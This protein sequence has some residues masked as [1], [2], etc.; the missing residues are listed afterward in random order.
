MKLNDRFNMI[1]RKKQII[2][3]S[4][5]LILFVF[6][7]LGGLTHSYASPEAVM[8]ACEKGLHYG[9]SEK[10]LL[11][12]KE[13]RNALV[14]GKCDGGLSSVKATKSGLAWNL[15]YDGGGTAIEGLCRTE[16]VGA[17]YDH[18]FNMVYGI[19]LMKDIS[20]VRL[21]VEDD[22][23]EVAE[24]EFETD[25]D[26]FFYG[27]LPDYEGNMIY[28]SETEGYNAAGEMILASDIFD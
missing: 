5:I 20:K 8:Y 10:V 27:K 17:W 18:E 2:I 25:E 9:P 22:S 21:T 28:I 16:T 7:R 3:F 24:L 19:S 26:G 15:G 14:I 4:L 1:S 12:E 6:W 11:V 13:G 23:S